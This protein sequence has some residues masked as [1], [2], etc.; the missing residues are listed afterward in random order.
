MDESEVEKAASKKIRN[1]RIAVGVAAVVAAIAAYKI[2]DSG[3]FRRLVEKGKAWG[4][5]SPPQWKKDS[6]LAA[7]TMSAEDIYRN[8][9]VRRINPDYGIASPAGFGTKNNCRRCTFAYELRR[10]GFDVQATKSTSGTGQNVLG[11]YSAT[12][13]KAI[14]GGLFG[15]LGRVV[16]G[17]EELINYFSD[18]GKNP[19]YA[20]GTPIKV[21]DDATSSAKAIFDSL[22]KQPERARGEL[23][24]HWKNGPKHSM[25]WEIINGKTV[26]YDCQTQSMFDS[27]DSFL[28]RARG[29]EEAGFTRLDNVELNNDFLLRWLKSSE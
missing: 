3:E 10:R 14:K 5:G 12:H 17:D 15:A 8:V 23:V 27:I 7:A 2:A 4:H 22:N 16:S 6:S 24:V 20:L 28:S 29:L 25:A 13:N 11:M 19:A 18:I 1:E 9:V 26:I 21:K